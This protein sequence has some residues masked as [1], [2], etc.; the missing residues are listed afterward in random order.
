MPDPTSPRD[1]GATTRSSTPT[2]PWDSFAKRL[3]Q[4]AV[5]RIRGNRLSLD[6]YARTRFRKE[7]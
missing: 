6:M 3:K 1:T 5:T 2:Y 7:N 4:D